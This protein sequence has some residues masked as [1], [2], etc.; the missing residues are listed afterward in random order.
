M[1]NRLH[2]KYKQSLPRGQAPL[3]GLFFISMKTCIL[4]MGGFRTYKIALAWKSEGMVHDIGLIPGGIIPVQ[5]AVRH[6]RLHI[7]VGIVHIL[8]LPRSI[9]PN[10]TSGFG[11]RRLVKLRYKAR[12][13]LGLCKRDGEA[14]VLLYLRCLERPMHRELESRL[15]TS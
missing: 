8:L 15:I 6:P 2:V 1:K 3:Y 5:S 10:T 11:H 7:L 14:S 12:S 4:L 13:C 9:W